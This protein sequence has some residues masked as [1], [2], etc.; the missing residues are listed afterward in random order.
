LRDVVS[1]GDMTS[2]ARLDRDTLKVNLDYRSQ[3]QNRILQYHVPGNISPLNLLTAS[4]TSIDLLLSVFLDTIQEFLTALGVLDV[5]DAEVH[6]LFHVT[7][8]DLLVDDHTDSGLGDVVDNTG[9][10]SSQ[11]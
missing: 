3:K 4:S 10:T 2:V 6:T 11:K 5:F 7:A 9:T 1:S 8:T